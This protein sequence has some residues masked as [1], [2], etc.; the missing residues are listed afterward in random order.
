MDLEVQVEAEREQ[1]HP[2]IFHEVRVHYVIK[3]RKISTTQVEHAIKLSTEKYCGASITVGRSGAKMKYTHEIIEL[4]FHK[5][6]TFFPEHKFSIEN[7]HN[8]YFRENTKN[9]F[10]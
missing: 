7:R 1:T 9:S 8:I 6:S 2:R 10:D 3:G 4:W 5:I